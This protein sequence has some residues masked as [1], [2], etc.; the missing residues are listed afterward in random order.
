[1]NLIRLIK[2]IF[3][4]DENLA[5][6]HLAFFFRDKRKCHYKNNNLTYFKHMY[7]SLRCALYFIPVVLFCIFH[8]FM[9]NIKSNWATN[10]VANFDNFYN[11]LKTKLS[12]EPK[13]PEWD[14]E[15]N[16]HEDL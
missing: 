3:N 4:K 8:A 13:K 11:S 1:M 14:M 15:F 5:Y 6:T 7:L 12:G 9:P 16:S 10:K 2:A